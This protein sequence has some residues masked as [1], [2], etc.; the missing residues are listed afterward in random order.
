MS[1][2]EYA[3]TFADCVI[4]RTEWDTVMKPGMVILMM[5]VPALIALFLV[6]FVLDETAGSVFTEDSVRAGI[7]IALVTECSV[8]SFLLYIMASRT[9][10]HQKRDEIWTDSLIGYVRSKGG[11]TDELESLAR[12]IHKRGRAPLRAIS[13]VLW[14]FSAVYLLFLAFY[15]FWTDGNISDHVYLYG[16]VG[17]IILIVQFLLTTGTT[18]GFPRSHEKA[19]IAF[20]EELSTQFSRVGIDVAPMERMVGK[21]H[22]IICIVLFVITLGLFSLILFIMSCRNMNLHLRNQWDYEERLLEAIIE[23][24]GGNGVRPA[25]GVKSGIG[26]RLIRSLM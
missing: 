21:P 1:R 15:F 5:F 4:R 7:L 6:T 12:K 18:Y 10:R 9:G 26:K 25:E 13:L 23:H 17:Y 20:T 8:V 14:G 11:S 3:D 19:Q 16:T 24:E 22:W 2:N